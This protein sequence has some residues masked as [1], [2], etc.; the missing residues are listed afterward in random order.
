VREQNTRPL[1]SAFHRYG[2]NYGGGTVAR[3]KGGESCVEESEYQFR[4]QL[5]DDEVKLQLYLEDPLKVL[6]ITQPLALSQVSISFGHVHHQK[7][8]DSIILHRKLQ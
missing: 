1:V 4:W 5:Q 7:V 2:W 8:N 6:Q 3:G